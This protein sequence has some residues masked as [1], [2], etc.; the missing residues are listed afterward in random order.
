MTVEVTTSTPVTEGLGTLFTLK[1]KEGKHVAHAGFVYAHQT[2][3]TDGQPTEINFFVDSSSNSNSSSNSSSPDGD[4]AVTEADRGLMAWE[5]LGQPFPEAAGFT[6]VVAIEGKVFA[7]NRALPDHSK[8]VALYHEANQTWERLSSAEA[9]I[10]S[11]G[12]V[13]DVCGGRMGFERRGITFNGECTCTCTCTD[14]P[15][16]APA[17]LLLLFFLFCFLNLPPTDFNM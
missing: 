16:C 13:L 3:Y 8:P 12:G 15:C 17:L 5:S 11:A 2:D 14:A 4:E 10:P 9:R 6:R 1:D 7:V